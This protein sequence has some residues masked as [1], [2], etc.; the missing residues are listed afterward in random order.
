MPAIDDD[1]RTRH[2]ARRIGHQQHERPVEI[3]EVSQR[4]AGMRLTKASAM[5]LSSK[6]LL[7]LV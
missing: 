5:S 2:V 6:V 4:R 3:L 7:T 1:D